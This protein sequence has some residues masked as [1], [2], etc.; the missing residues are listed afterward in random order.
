MD[1][2]SKVAEV[3]AKLKAKGFVSPYLRAFVVGRIN[4]LRE[5][6]THA[7]H[8]ATVSPT[9]AQEI[10]TP[11]YSYGLEELLRSRA[12]VLSGILNGV[13]YQEW[14]P[15]NDRFLPQHF[16]ASQLGIK[17]RF[18]KGQAFKHPVS[19]ASRISRRS[20]RCAAHVP[21]GVIDA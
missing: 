21:G 19:A 15:R 14:D 17:A 1:L 18:I 8:V 2:D 6:I 9:Y 12:N 4:P 13:D 11:A 10:Q 16:N 3:I 5:G 7:D 20:G